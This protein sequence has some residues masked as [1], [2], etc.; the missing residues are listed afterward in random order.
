MEIR[1]LRYFVTSVQEEGITA[2]ADVLHVSQPTISRQIREL[3]EELGATLFSRG[4]RGH[5]LNLTREGRMLYRRA[6]EIIELAD[7]AESEITSRETIEGDLHIDAAQ[8]RSMNIVAKALVQ[9]HERHPGVRIHLQDAYSDDIIERL[10]NGLT[11]FGVLMQPLDMSRYDHFALP[12]DDV[13]GLVVR[14]DDPLATHES[15]TAGDLTGIPLIMPRGAISR[16]DAAAQVD[17][18]A[19]GY[20][21]I[22]ATINL[23]HNGTYLVSQGLGS[24]LCLK[25][26]VNV[27]DDS[28]LVFIPLSPRTP[29]RINIAW[30]K[31]Q[32]LPRQAEVFLEILRT[33]I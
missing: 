7:K 11:D 25:S 2:A 8:T 3:E 9:L 16:N 15:V 6:C 17:S 5:T 23:A 13:M 32:T 33:M 20:S 30:K 19:S 10:N 29:V 22:V 12:D 28:G 1:A 21:Q 14:A 31:N 18:S 4:N 27:G 26:V 24:M